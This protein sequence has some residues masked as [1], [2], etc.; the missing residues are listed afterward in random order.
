MEYNGDYGLLWGLKFVW[1]RD[2]GDS[3]RFNIC[4]MVIS[5]DI[6]EILWDWDIDDYLATRLDHFGVR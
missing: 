3:G 5:L 6:S 2:V 1:L 4:L